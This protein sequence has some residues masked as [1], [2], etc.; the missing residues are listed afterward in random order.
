MIKRLRSRIRRFTQAILLISLSLTV[1][2]T[3]FAIIEKYTLL[4]AFYMS[5]I[6]LSTVGFGEVRELSNLGKIFTAFYIIFNIAIVA[7]IVS[8]ISRF[9]FEGELRDIFSNFVTLREVKKM[10]NHVIVC[11]Y[12]RNGYNACLELKRDK[13]PFVVI[14]K[15]EDRVIQ[16]LDETD[17]PFIKGDATEEEVLKYAGIE[18]AKAIIAAIP[19]DAINV[20]I[21][22][23]AR[24]L[25]VGI[26][27]IA[28]ASSPSSERKLMR[29]GANSVVLPDALGGHY[30]AT[31]VNKP[32]VIEFLDML[33]GKGGMHLEM[34][35]INYQEFRA[36]YRDKTIR[37]L[38]VRKYSGVTFIGYKSAQEGYMFNPSSHVR[39]TEG[40]IVI[41]LGSREEIDIFKRQF[42]KM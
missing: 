37:E 7:Y 13:V 24:E 3:G 4:E 38:D 19:T 26:Q 6:T 16:D 27:I 41:A 9:L 36:E 31:L 34:E 17:I 15:D 39:L 1:G 8:V 28:R 29:A 32:E 40:D 14:D 25:N 42:T 35:E 22:L 30:M 21:A 23:T 11:G 2:V 18:K 10:K 12:G 5:V 33:N 20:F